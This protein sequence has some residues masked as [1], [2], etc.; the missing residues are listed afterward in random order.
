MAL[1]NQPRR[2]QRKLASDVC[3]VHATVLQYPRNEKSPR[4]SDQSEA[5]SMTVARPGER[6]VAHA[7]PAVKVEGGRVSVPSPRE[8][9]LLGN[10]HGVS[11]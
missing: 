8:L 11:V 7:R 4:D 2:P 9:H 3:V 10:T 6:I 1:P 5:L